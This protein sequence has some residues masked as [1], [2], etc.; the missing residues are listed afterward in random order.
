MTALR[1]LNAKHDGIGQCSCRVKHVS[2]SPARVDVAKKVIFEYF[3]T[4]S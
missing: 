4:V 2:Y 1:F 3:P